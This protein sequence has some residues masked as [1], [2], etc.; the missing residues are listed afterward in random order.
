MIL[1]LLSK[2]S[3]AYK[4][5]ALHYRWSEQLFLVNH[6]HSQHSLFVPFVLLLHG[7][8][9]LHNDQFVSKSVLQSN[10]SRNRNDECVFLPDTRTHT[11]SFLFIRHSPPTHTYPFS[12]YDIFNAFPDVYFIMCLMH[13]IFPKTFHFVPCSQTAAAVAVTVAAK[14]IHCAQIVQFVLLW[15]LCAR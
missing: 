8:L 9:L 15:F 11:H 12:I 14:A 4:V 3:I 10:S 5:L 1:L 2:A 7:Y 13:S 6:Q